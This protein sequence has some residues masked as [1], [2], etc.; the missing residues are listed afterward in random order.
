MSYLQQGS[1]FPPCSHSWPI[2]RCFRLASF[3]PIIIFDLKE[4]WQF[5]PIENECFASS[6][7]GLLLDRWGDFQCLNFRALFGF[8]LHHRNALGDLGLYSI[9][10]RECFDVRSSCVSDILQLLLEVVLS[11]CCLAFLLLSVAPEELFDSGWS[12]SHHVKCWA[13]ISHQNCLWLNLKS[14]LLQA[15]TFAA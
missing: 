13:Y 4:L 1:V 14:S 6:F 2:I 9:G 15:T 10:R 3:R 12:Y 7:K 5:V 11:I 8:T